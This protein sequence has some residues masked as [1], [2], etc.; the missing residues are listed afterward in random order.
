MSNDRSW[1]DPEIHRERMPTPFALV[2]KLPLSTHYGLSKSDRERPK[3]GL[4]GAFERPFG[5][6]DS[7][8]TSARRRRAH[9][10]PKTN[11]GIPN[12][13]VP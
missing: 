4:S 10:R 13:P 8:V 1:P 12:Q 7:C 2:L 9:I 6:V 3:L 5:T 11:V